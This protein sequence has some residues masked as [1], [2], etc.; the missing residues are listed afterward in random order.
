M[1]VAGTKRAKV[2]V[3]CLL[4]IG[5]RGGAGVLV[6]HDSGQTQT[7]SVRCSIYQVNSK[8]QVTS[9]RTQQ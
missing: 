6:N 1:R 7:L 5:Y 9:Q 3:R 4:L 8:S 2:A